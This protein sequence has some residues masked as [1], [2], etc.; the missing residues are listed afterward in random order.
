[1]DPL[2]LYQLEQRVNAFLAEEE[3]D[4]AIAHVEDELDDI[5][6][7]IFLESSKKDGS[8]MEGNAQILYPT[9]HGFIIRTDAGEEMFMPKKSYKG[10]TV[11]EGTRILC[12]M[13]ST[14]DKGPTCIDAQ[15]C[16]SL[17]EL[18]YRMFSYI[19]ER[20]M[21]KA[22]SAAWALYKDA[23]E[24]NQAKMKLCIHIL[25]NYVRKISKGE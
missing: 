21:V 17:K 6:G 18:K 11:K 15:E 20:D 1:M 8:V 2:D 3:P 23:S 4:E 12:G 5:L 19:D 24:Q 9:K 10:S 22:A 7:Q 14:N 16:L 13:F 25:R